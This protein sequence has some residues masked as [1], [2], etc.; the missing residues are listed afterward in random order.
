MITFSDLLGKTLV[1]VEGRKGDDSITF[2]VDNGD[3][4]V[5]YHEQDCCESV[6][7]ED[8]CGEMSDLI[9]S[10]ILQAE[11]S[12]SNENPSDMLP[13]KYQ[14][15]FTWTFYRIATMKGQVVIRWYGES[16]GYY[17]E[18]VSFKHWPKAV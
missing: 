11:E 12:T 10:P 16:N 13:P 3:A 2:R 15:S 7:V 17:S 1:A 6:R 18:E 5:L 14:E 8:I 9:G 4:Y